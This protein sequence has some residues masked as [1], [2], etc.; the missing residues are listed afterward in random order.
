MSDDNSFVVNLGGGLYL[1]AQGKLRYTAP[2]GAQVY[3]P[4]AGL[5]VDTKKI[6]DL[7]KDL[8]GILPEDDDAQAKW[9]KWGVPMD[10]A[11][12]LGSIAGIV[13]IVATAI[14][15][16]AWI[17]SAALYIAGQ[18]AG[19]DG[20]SPALGQAHSPSGIA[21]KVRVSRRAAYIGVRGAWRRVAGSAIHRRRVEGQ[22]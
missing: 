5:K 16:Y 14:S 8:A 6:E 2:D 17:V 4:P 11:R 7:F 21:A 15:I 3:R 10:V 13:G 22:L 12:F 19:D 1:D 20:I 18:V 9:A